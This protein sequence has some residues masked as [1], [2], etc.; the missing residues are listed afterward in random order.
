MT[1]TGSPPRIRFRDYL[2]AVLFSGGAARE[3]TSQEQVASFL[4]RFLAPFE[5]L[6][7]ELQREIEGEADGTGGIPDLFD[8]DLTPPAQFTHSTGDAFQ[9]LR[10]LASWV[11]LGLR[12]E[13]PVEW[14]R[15]YFRQALELSD[16]RGTLAGLDALL[17][18]WLLGDLLETDPPQLVLTDLIRP[19][20][21]V[22]AVFQ[23]DPADP[24]VLGVNT[25]LGEG[26]PFF[27]VVD[28][29]ADPTVRDLRNPIGLDVLQRAART[30]LDTEK[31]ASS[32][33]QLRVRTTTMQ[34]APADPAD[35]RPRE[36]Y[37]QLED[38][39]GDPPLLGTTLLWDEPAVF[40]SD[41]T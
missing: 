9:H 34:L 11:G 23:L 10:H 36:I 13:K 28:L 20:N 31:P 21:D 37:A 14:N 4:S 17:R 41:Q 7:E 24:P 15:H 27:F 5:A 2:P 6:F 16:R 26:P 32:H 39:T 35:A 38:Q 40:D 22:D 8:P 19:A 29:P 30:L 33:Y 3:A 18:A 1:P 12:P 25:I